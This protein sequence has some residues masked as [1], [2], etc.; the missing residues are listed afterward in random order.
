MTT[1]KVKKCVC[2][3]PYASGDGRNE[4][5]LADPNCIICC[6]EGLYLI[7]V[8]RLARTLA[9][10]RYNGTALEMLGEQLERDLLIEAA[11]AYREGVEW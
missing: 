5:E 2:V 6:G 10:E 3:M 9:E 1:P 7:E 8:D 11:E 4:R